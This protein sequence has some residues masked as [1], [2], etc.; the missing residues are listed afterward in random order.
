MP[1][2]TAT[3]L[4]EPERGPRRTGLLDAQGNDLWVIDEPAPLG[5]DL[6]KK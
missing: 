6:S 4:H 5:F 3:V 1:P 2:M